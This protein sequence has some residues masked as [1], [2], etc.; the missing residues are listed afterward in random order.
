MS[1]SQLVHVQTVVLLS[2]SVGCALRCPMVH[3]SV[4]RVNDCNNANCN[5]KGPT[6]IDG[7]YSRR[8]FSSP[9]GILH[10]CVHA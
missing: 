7:S 8:R 3:Y 4:A 1:T 10:G 2:T 9:T 5:G 6:V